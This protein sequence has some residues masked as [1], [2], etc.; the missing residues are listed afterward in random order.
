MADIDV[1]VRETQ[2][3]RLQFGVGV[4]SD[5]GLTGS[6]VIDER[7]FDWRRFPSSYDEF[8]NSTAFR[9]GGQ[10]FRLEALPGKDVQ[11]YMFSL[12]EPYL[13][14]TNVMLNLSAYY[15]SRRYFDWSEQR[16][17]GRIGLGYQLSPAL[18]IGCSIRA[19]KVTIYDPRVS[20]VPELT[21]AVGKHGLYSG[22]VSISHDTRDLPFAPTEGHLVKLD[23]EQVF[24]D[25]D[26]A[27]ANLD[28]RQYFLI[29]EGLNGAGRQ[30]LSYS[31]RFGV[32]GSQTPIFENYFAGG[33]STLRGFDFR[34]FATRR[35]GCCWW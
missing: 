22:R 24:G 20:T 14:N 27:R 18:S 9:G 31:F 7:N 21:D 17:C 19:E 34:C 33:Y 2:T 12:G 6:F 1:Y 16:V 35:I 23:F 10:R 5:A 11:R 26:Y 15:F 4:N 8:V 3:G 13:F 32:T 28:Y 25:Y 29:W 30:V